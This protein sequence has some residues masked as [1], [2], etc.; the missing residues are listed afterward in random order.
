MALAWLGWGDKPVEWR[1]EGWL[2]CSRYNFYLCELHLYRSNC[3]LLILSTWPPN[4]TSCFVAAA[5]HR[6][7]CRHVGSFLWAH[8]NGPSETLNL[9][10]LPQTQAFLST[11]VRSNSDTVKVGSRQLAVLVTA[12]RLMSLQELV[13]YTIRYYDDCF[14]RRPKYICLSYCYA[15]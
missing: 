2:Q 10:C 1:G 15:R 7:T 9:S 14:L 13:Y 6:P 11:S 4:K 3:F 12:I 8:E 5:C